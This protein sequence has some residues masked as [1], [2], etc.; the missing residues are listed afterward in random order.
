MNK[1]KIKALAEFITTGTIFESSNFESKIVQW[2][3]QNTIERVWL[4]D[5]Q[6]KEVPVGLSDEQVTSLATR[7]A[8]MLDIPH[9]KFIG[10]YNEWKLSQTF[11]HYNE[12][13]VYEPNWD[14]APEWAT[15]CRVR[16]HWA[17]DNHSTTGALLHT[18]QRPK[19]PTSIVEVGQIWKINRR[20]YKVLAISE[21]STDCI[22]YQKIVTYIELDN[23]HGALSKTLDNFLAKFD[24]VQL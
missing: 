14:D 12:G 4:T 20:E 3:K 2:F 18:E 7:V 22:N 23:D 10:Q 13:K 15:E 17:D 6:I 8:V 19:P 5:T 9:I 11:S 1:E 16:V 21:F 24:Q